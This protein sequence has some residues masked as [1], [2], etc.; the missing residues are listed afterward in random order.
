MYAWQFAKALFLQQR[1]GWARFITMQD[2]YNLMYREEEREMHPFCLDQGVGALPYSPLARGRL[3]RPWG[4]RTQR[5]DYDGLGHEL[6]AGNAEAD[7]RITDA[8]GDVAAARGVS[9]ARVALAWVLA[10]P[11][12]SAPLVGAT[13]PAHVDDDAAALDLQL[14]DEEFSLLEQYY[15]PRPVAGF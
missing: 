5:Q 10:N 15:V 12:V 14:S 6:Y 4:A 8:V 1:H 3:A 13:D 2:H 9:R 11:A 7:R